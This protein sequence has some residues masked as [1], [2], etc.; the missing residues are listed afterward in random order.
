MPT[1]KTVTTIAPSD[2]GAACA[3]EL[4]N[5]SIRPEEGMAAENGNNGI[6]IP[7]MAVLTAFVTIGVAVNGYMLARMDSVFERFGD[8]LDRIHEKVS[9]NSSEIAALKG[10]KWTSSR[11]SGT[12]S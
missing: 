4:G 1:T 6:R 2:I 3:V 7:L 12:G 9:D 5:Q 11:K 8:K 10:Q